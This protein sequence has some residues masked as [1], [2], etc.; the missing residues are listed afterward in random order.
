MLH[1]E[2]H[3]YSEKN[4]EDNSKISMVLLAFCLI[5]NIEDG[6]KLLRH[7]DQDERETDAAVH[8]DTIRPELL[9]GFWENDAEEFKYSESI[10]HIHKGSNEVR[11][12][13]CEASQESLAYIRAIQGHSGGEA[14]SPQMMGHVLC[15]KGWKELIHH[16]GCYFNMKSILEHGLVAGGNRSKGGRQTVF[17]LATQSVGTR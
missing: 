5:A 11:F 4:V 12:K 17:V 8:G 3:G 1:E 16:K 7:F 9:R 6:V 13:Y 14:I 10:D 15:P 2:N